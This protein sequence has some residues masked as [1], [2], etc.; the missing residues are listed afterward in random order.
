VCLED[1]EI[2]K[3]LVLVFILH[4]KEGA[5]EGGRLLTEYACGLIAFENNKAYGFTCHYFGAE[6]SS[7]A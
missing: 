3:I 6:P 5:K 1:I 7:Y 4:Q 2:K